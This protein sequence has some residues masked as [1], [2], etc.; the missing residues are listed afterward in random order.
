VLFVS[1]SRPHVTVIART[2]QGWEEREFRAGQELTLQAPELSF[3]IDEL[4]AG[5]ALDDA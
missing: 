2:Q 5:I 1:H 3:S 4:Y